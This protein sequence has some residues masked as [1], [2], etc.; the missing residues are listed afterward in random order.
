MKHIQLFFRKLERRLVYEVC[1]WLDTI[2]HNMN[3]CYPAECSVCYEEHYHGPHRPSEFR[4]YSCEACGWTP[5][6]EFYYVRSNKHYDCTDFDEKTKRMI[7]TPPEGDQAYPTLGP[8]H[9][10]YGSSMEF[11]GEA[12]D[13]KETHRCPFHGEFTFIN[14]NC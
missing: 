5:P 14:S 12:Y 8:K 4:S 3:R 9:Y 7:A 6:E 1:Y 13:W 2:T 11:G 10:N